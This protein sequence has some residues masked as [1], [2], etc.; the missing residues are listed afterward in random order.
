M[1]YGN[2]WQSSGVRC[3][4]VYTV[5][6]KIEPM[7]KRICASFCKMTEHNLSIF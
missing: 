2:T 7:I 6:I 5:Y 4:E 1:K 3:T